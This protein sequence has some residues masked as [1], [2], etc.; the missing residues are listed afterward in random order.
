MRR[1]KKLLFPTH[2]KHLSFSS[3]EK[4]LTLKSSGL[5]KVVFLHVMDR[6]EVGYVP[7]GG[8]DKELAKEL[9]EKAK[10]T[11]ADWGSELE[12]RGVAWEEIVEIGNPEVKIIEVASREGVDLIVTGKHTKITDSFYP[13][14]VEFEVL[15]NS[16]LPVLV[17]TDKREADESAE[18]KD[19]LRHVLVATDFS[20]LANAALDLILGFGNTA[21]SISLLH[22]VETAQVERLTPA[23]LDEANKEAG[24]KLAETASK[25]LA[26]GMNADTHLLTGEAARVIVDFAAD[27]GCT[28]IA[29][30][31]RR[32][33]G[34]EEVFH[35]SVSHSVVTE[36]AEPVFIVTAR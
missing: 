30:G 3:L 7:F 2:F 18:D 29:L 5:E 28:S 19:L 26:L 24:R 4:V 34:V 16:T 12:M 10:L 15:R 13:S 14:G 11:F 20:D 32:L 1:I 8:F 21:G 22:V 9:G 27:R 31:S 33:G 35:G 36:S 17:L 25:V 23:E 6:D